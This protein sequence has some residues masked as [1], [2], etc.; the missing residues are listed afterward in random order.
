[1]AYKAIKINGKKHDLHRVVGEN[2]AGKKLGFNEVVHHVDEDKL[3]NDPDNLKILS[4]S[5][6][7]SL[8]MKGRKLKEETKI[9]LKEVGINK[10]TNAKL[11]IEEVKKIKGYL[12]AGLSGKEIK[13][14]AGFERDIVSRIKTGK[15]W[16]WVTI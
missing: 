7:S 5:E 4:R 9:K 15:R 13:K 11:S 8:H 2:K 10:R 14:I 12:A 1:M 16:S 3:N 6:H